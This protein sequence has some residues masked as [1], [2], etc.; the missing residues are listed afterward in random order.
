MEN[1]NNRAESDR[2]TLEES[3]QF[4]CVSASDVALRSVRTGAD[5]DPWRVGGET[6]MAQ[7]QEKRDEQS[8]QLL[9]NM[10]KLRELEAE[11]RQLED[12]VEGIRQ[13]EKL[14]DAILSIDVS[15]RD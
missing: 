15:K 8:K 2:N 3:D 14:S 10:A 11:K 6:N 9:D 4:E 7:I 13:R 5:G 1:N 12:V